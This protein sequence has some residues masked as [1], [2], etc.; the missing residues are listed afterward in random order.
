MSLGAKNPLQ[1]MKLELVSF[2]SSSSII[3]VTSSGSWEKKNSKLSYKNLCFSIHEFHFQWLSLTCTPIQ[4]SYE[5][6][7]P[8]QGQS[9]QD[10]SVFIDKLWRA[11]RGFMEGKNNKIIWWYHPEL[12]PRNNKYRYFKNEELC[13]GLNYLSL[14]WGVQLS[15]YHLSDSTI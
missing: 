2:M 3:Y 12:Y 8:K 15:K 6:R 1:L 11:Y 14:I 4:I 10:P 13:E 7:N 9:P 5:E